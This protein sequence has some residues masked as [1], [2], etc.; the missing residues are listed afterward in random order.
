MRTDAVLCCRAV[1]WPP[2]PQVSY[3]CPADRLLDVSVH[4]AE[5]PVGS[6]LV[7]WLMRPSLAEARQWLYDAA[8]RSGVVEL[9]QL[10]DHIMF[11]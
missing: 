3:D 10:R 8:Y 2:P 1:P 4:T 11:M 6:P 9:R 7:R 5:N